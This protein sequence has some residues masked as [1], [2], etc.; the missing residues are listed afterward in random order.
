MLESGLVEGGEAVM[1]DVV[2]V[3]VGEE[4]LEPL[5]HDLVVGP[6]V[7]QLGE[8]DGPALA[9]LVLQGRTDGLDQVVLDGFPV[10]LVEIS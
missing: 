5:V 4:F 3:E 2:P 9:D 1:L 7:L 10:T 6:A 8:E